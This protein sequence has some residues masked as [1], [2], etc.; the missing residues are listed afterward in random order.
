MTTVD[1]SVEAQHDRD[2]DQAEKAGATVTTRFF[3]DLRDLFGA[4]REIRLTEA[5]DVAGLLA[6]LCD[7]PLRRSALRDGHGECGKRVAILVNGRN[8]TF[9]GGE[10]VELNDGDVIDFFPPVFGG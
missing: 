10:S 4:G 7:S 1:C 6:A 8:I 3:A 9:L 5:R 2:G